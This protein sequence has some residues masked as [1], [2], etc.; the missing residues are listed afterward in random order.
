MR[1]KSLLFRAGIQR[2]TQLPQVPQIRSMVDIV[3]YNG[4][5]SLTHSLTK[6]ANKLHSDKTSKTILTVKNA[7]LNTT[8]ATGDEY[9]RT[10]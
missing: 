1:S 10:G 3:R 6:I 2:L 9:K 5:H 8:G 7:R 4:F